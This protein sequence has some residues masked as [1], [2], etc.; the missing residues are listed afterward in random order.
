[1]VVFVVVVV[2][3]VVG[4]GGGGGGVV[5]GTCMTVFVGQ[6][7]FSFSA[8]Q[9]PDPKISQ[10]ALNPELFPEKW[11]QPALPRVNATPHVR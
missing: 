8:P 6:E 7:M 9:R 1:M 2:V 10:R 4:G 3:V 11:L 5:V